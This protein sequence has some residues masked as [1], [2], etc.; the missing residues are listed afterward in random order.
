[1]EVDGVGT[2]C[3]HCDQ[4]RRHG[5]QQITRGWRTIGVLG[6]LDAHDLLNH[7]VRSAELHRLMRNLLSVVPVETTPQR[8]CDGHYGNRSEKS[9]HSLH[10]LSLIFCRDLPHTS[11][12]N[13]IWRTAPPFVDVKRQLE[14]NYLAQCGIN[15]TNAMVAPQL[16]SGTFRNHLHA[17]AGLA[18]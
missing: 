4:R 12:V 15:H 3:R 13:Q 9:F 6:P 5:I 11:H 1:M 16:E 7:G 18:A 14:S 8:G 2:P 10:G 17:G